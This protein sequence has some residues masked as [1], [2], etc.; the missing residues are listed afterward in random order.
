[1]VGPAAAPPTFSGAGRRRGGLLLAVLTT[2]VL[3]AVALAIRNSASG[4]HV[5][6]APTGTTSPLPARAGEP[7]PPSSR[8]SAS[9]DG[10]QPPV[11]T[12]TEGGKSVNNGPV[13]R[14][15]R[16]AASIAPAPLIGTSHARSHSGSGRR[17]RAH[18]RYRWDWYR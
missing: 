17:V 7:V 8:T 6:S 4:D 9:A 1:V 5:L 14:S 16:K 18:S 3:V 10:Q 11:S 15:D 13:Y 2:M 12:Q